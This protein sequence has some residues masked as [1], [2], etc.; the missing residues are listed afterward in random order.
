MTKKEKELEETLKKSVL[1][2]IRADKNRFYYIAYLVSNS[3]YFSY[4]VN[5]CIIANTVI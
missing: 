4:I 1:A 5:L 2:L 3:K